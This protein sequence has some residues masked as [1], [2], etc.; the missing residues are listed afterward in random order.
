MRNPAER[1][2]GWLNWGQLVSTLGLKYKFDGSLFVL[3]LLDLASSGAIK[4][5]SPALL[6]TAGPLAHSQGHH[7]SGKK[8]VLENGG[9]LPPLG[10][11]ALLFT[12]MALAVGST[13][14][15]FSLKWHCLGVGPSNVSVPQ[16]QITAD[17][18][19]CRS[20]GRAEGARSLAPFLVYGKRCCR[21]LLCV[22]EEQGS[23]G[24][25]GLRPGT[26]V[27]SRLGSSLSPDLLAPLLFKGA[28]VRFCDP[29][30]FMTVPWC[31]LSSVYLVS[32]P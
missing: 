22:T 8:K 14:L 5:L 28:L 12:Q 19:C 30:I 16:F 4:Q 21:Y 20:C 2:Y 10:F 13:P 29:Q 1:G 11:S 32:L 18:N 23:W 6:V 26:E 7:T 24:A 31:P 9:C 25:L 3:C 15:V 17:K 27:F